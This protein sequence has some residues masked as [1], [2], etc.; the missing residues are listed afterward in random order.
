MNEVLASEPEN[1]LITMKTRWIW[2]YPGLWALLI[3]IL[4]SLP[5]LTGPQIFFKMSDKFWHVVVYL[6]LGFLLSLATETQPGPFKKSP[7][8]WSV[9]LGVAYGLTDEFH[10]YFVPGRFMEV[11]DWGADALGV[12]IGVGLFY[13]ARA[14]KNRPHRHAE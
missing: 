13:L 4:S 3:F 5:D 6:P 8:F 2:L 10:Q 11:F 9:F 14:L 7:A 12:F 1:Y